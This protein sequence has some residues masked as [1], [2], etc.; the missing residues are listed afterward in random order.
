MIEDPG[1]SSILSRCSKN[2]LNEFNVSGV[3][4]SINDGFD[5]LLRGRL[6]KVELLDGSN[7]NVVDYKTGNPK[8]R[9][10]IEGETKNSE[11]NYKRQLVFY[12]LLLDRFEPGRFVMKTGEIDFVEPNKQGKYKRERFEVTEREV[13]DLVEVIKKAAQE[14][15]NLEFW[16]K[17]CTDPECDFCKMRKLLDM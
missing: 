8:S 15:I 10:D 5:I 4:L 14:I 16:D 13:D 9:R 17:N 12:K 11:G 7:V 2:I 1:M 6:D 3:H